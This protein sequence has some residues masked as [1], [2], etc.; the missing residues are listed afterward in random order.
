M[1]GWVL[2]L[3]C[4]VQ[5]WL[6]VDAWGVIAHERIAKIA[7]SL[8]KG[9]R[10]D[11]IRTILHGDLIDYAD[12]EKKMTDRHPETEVL[13]WHAQTPE[14]NCM[15]TLGEHEHLRCDHENSAAKGSLFCALAFFFEHFTHDALLRE[16]PEPKEPINTPKSLPPLETVTSMELT[17]AH[18]LRWLVGLIGD[19]HQPLHWLAQ[20]DYG[21]DIT[22]VYKDRPYKMLEFWE[23]E[24]P[25]HLP[26]IS[27]AKTLQE[28]YDEREHVWGH[29]LPTE[30]FR[31]WAKESAEVVCSQVYQGM[32][33][34]HA[35]GSRKIDDPYHL[36][37]EV[38]Q[39]WAKIANDFTTLA[40]ERVAFVL[41]DVLEHKRHKAG[42]KDGRGHR[43]RHKRHMRNLGINILVAVI[44]VPLLLKCLWWHE[45]QGKAFSLSSLFGMDKGKL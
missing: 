37:E 43:H 29:R 3:V 10:K 6:S 15:S 7:E 26:E 5:N 21:R 34:N 42:H 40:G 41:L 23:N 18:Y 9:K 19:L 13:H 1:P 44:L 32:E 35:D 30:L 8:L 31:I 27:D 25:L 17:P 45:K 39:R 11:Q 28:Q 20:H 14:W 2:C 12:W 24:L 22:I 33:V 38:L 36:D 4:F 16:F